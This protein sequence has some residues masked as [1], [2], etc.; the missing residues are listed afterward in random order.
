MNRARQPKRADAPTREYHRA[1]F[2]SAMTTRHDLDG[3]E[4]FIA[5]W[6]RAT[7]WS[8]EVLR[9]KIADVRRH[10]AETWG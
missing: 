5:G 1:Q 3:L 7:G 6:S 4:P 10:R 2:L 9:S 8:E